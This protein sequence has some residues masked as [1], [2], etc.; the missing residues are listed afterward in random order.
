MLYDPLILFSYLIYYIILCVGYD[1]GIILYCIVGYGVWYN[2]MYCCW[3]YG[4]IIYIVGVGV[5]GV[6]YYI[7]IGYDVWNIFVM[8]LVLIL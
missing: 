6:I 2:I 1:V 3:C 8:L 7:V 5:A 4:D